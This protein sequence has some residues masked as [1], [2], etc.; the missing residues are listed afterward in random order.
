MK[1]K[2]LELLVELILFIIMLAVLLSLLAG[3]D[4]QECMPEDMVESGF[5]EIVLIDGSVIFNPIW[6]CP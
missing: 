2:T 3:C 1:P 4:S 5:E 6:R